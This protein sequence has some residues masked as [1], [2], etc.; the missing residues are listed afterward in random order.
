[1]FSKDLNE[2]VTYKLK[3][4]VE[5]ENK[6]N[7]NGLIYKT[8]DKKK[9]KTFDFLKLKTVRSFVREIYNNDLSVDDPLEQQIRLKDNIDIFKEFTKPKESVKKVKKA[10]TL[11]HEIISLNGR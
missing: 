10:L 5:M 3:K 11:K 2:E 1:M 4:I 6:L 8:G 9:V 7:R